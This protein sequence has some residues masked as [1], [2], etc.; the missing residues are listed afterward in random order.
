[1]AATFDYAHMYLIMSVCILNMYAHIYANEINDSNDKRKWE[2]G[3]RIT[4]L[5]FRINITCKVVQCY[6]KED[7]DYL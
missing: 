4:L 2:G 1:M 3:I 5:F 6:L 7:W